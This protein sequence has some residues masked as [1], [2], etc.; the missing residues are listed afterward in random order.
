MYPMLATVLSKRRQK[1][2][3][4]LVYNRGAD[5]VRSERDCQKRLRTPS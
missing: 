4:S 3:Q 2:R 1:Y 5:P